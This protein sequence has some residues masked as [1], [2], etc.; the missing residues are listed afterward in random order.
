MFSLVFLVMLLVP[1]AVLGWR[2]IVTK[3]RTRWIRIG[4]AAAVMTTLVG[5]F[6]IF[7]SIID[8]SF[9]NWRDDLALLAA[10]SGSFYLFFWALRKHSNRRHRTISLIGAFIGVVPAL[11]AVAAAFSIVE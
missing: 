1:A 7:D 2:I 4:A 8:F 11:A 6:V 10:L 9:R 5:S 3:S